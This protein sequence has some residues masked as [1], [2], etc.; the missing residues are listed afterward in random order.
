MCKKVS[1]GLI[2]A[3]S[4]HD[5]IPEWQDEGTRHPEEMIL[6]TQE[7]KELQQIMTNYVGIVRSNLRLNRAL[8]RLDILY[9][10]T[11]RLYDRSKVSKQICE[12]RNSINI[13]YLIIK[14]AKRRKESRGLHYTLDYPEKGKIL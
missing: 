3:F 10:E 9:N 14:M 4:I 2:H 5:E 8:S 1:A 13:A 11:R 7:F 12:L 6:I